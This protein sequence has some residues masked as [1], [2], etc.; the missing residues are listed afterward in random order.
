VKVNRTIDEM[1][2]AHLLNSRQP[3][4]IE[5]D[6]F[7]IGIYLG[8]RNRNGATYAKLASEW[9][10][11][12]EWVR[13]MLKQSARRLRGA[14]L[15]RES[16]PNYHFRLRM[17]VEYGFCAYANELL[18]VDFFNSSTLQWIEQVKIQS[19]KEQRTLLDNQLNDTQHIE[20][21]KLPLRVTNCLTAANISTFN[22]LYDLGYDKIRAL[23]N[24]GSKSMHDLNVYLLSKGKSE[25]S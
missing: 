5:G 22:Q 11:T 20:L 25:L 24:M 9:N 10:R 17:V 1:R 7:I 23:P 14:Y 18:G 16:H 4:Q 6:K 21:A 15:L 3:S 19:N 12:G 13:Y 2:H 8:D